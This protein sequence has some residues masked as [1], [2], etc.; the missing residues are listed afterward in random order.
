MTLERDTD[1]RLRAWTTEGGIDRAPERFVWAALD[2][3]ERIPQRAAWRTRLDRITLR[4]RPAAGL[5][6]VAAAL[7]VAVFVITRVLGPNIGPGGPR[8]FVIDD[9][10]SIVLWEDTMP[11]TWTLDNLVSN[12]DEV[13]FIP[14]R[15]MTR[16]EYI[17]LGAPEGYLWGRYTDFTGPDGVFISWATLF[18]SE[19]EAAAALSFYEREMSAGDGWG[20][21]P[22]QP[23][24]L[25]DGG[26]V[27]AGPTTALVGPPTGVDP[28]PGQIF[29]WRNGNLLLA[30]GGWFDFDPAQLE[31]VA[32][33]V[34]A[35][36]DAAA[37]NPEPRPS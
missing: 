33:G 29:L 14:V 12:P 19:A 28:I 10:P 9:L 18:E 3:I 37:R 20:F 26:N 30:V 17:A 22:G 34:D 13:R 8:A 23:V 6:G 15:T 36:A 27:Y 4:L 21:G 16:D 1:R 25:G 7:L 32:E 11:A 2:Q 5:A 31:A 35:R 24:A